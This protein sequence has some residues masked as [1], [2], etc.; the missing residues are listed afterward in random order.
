MIIRI[1][2]AFLLSMAVTMVG[3]A[4]AQAQQQDQLKVC[5]VLREFVGATAQTPGQV[6]LGTRSFILAAGTSIPRTEAAAP[7]LGTATC[8]SATQG[9]NG[10]LSA[11]VFTGVPSPA[12]GSVT[13]LTQGAGVT[14]GEL[15]LAGFFRLFISA[16]VTLPPEAASG[17]HCF[18][19]GIDGVGDAVVLR[20]VPS[21]E[22]QG[23]TLPAAV[24]TPAAAPR[25]TT[26]PSTATRGGGLGMVLVLGLVVVLVAA[27]VAHLRRERRATL[28]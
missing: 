22:P 16:G 11:Y 26:L 21:P 7:P 2:A 9:S 15:T 6:T 3:T 28:G 20:E 13:S 23:P 12:C 27:S 14:R 25:V 19:I 17:T 8:V 5:G 24:S 1:G 4:S 18:E 10:Q